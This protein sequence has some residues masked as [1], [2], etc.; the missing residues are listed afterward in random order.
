MLLSQIDADYYLVINDDLIFI[1]GSVDKPLAYMERP[2]NSRVGM[3]G[4][5]LLNADGSLQPSTYS[6]AGIFRAVLS[7]SN[8][9][10]AI[11]LTSKLF[12]LASFLRLD[13]GKSRYWPHTKTVEV[14]SFRGAYMLIRKAALQEVGLL[15]VKGGEE[16]EWH[17]RFHKHGW[18]VIFFHE[19]EIIHL[20][21]MTT[22]TDP[23]SELIFL[24]SFLNIYYK[25]MSRWRYG[26]LRFCFF[27]TYLAKYLVEKVR[28]TAQR[29]EFARKGLVMI[30]YW[31]QEVD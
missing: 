17:M 1:P 10:S 24:R 18:K 5:R 26:V 8:L 9:R 30:W 21:S 19:A 12:R 6:F 28:G 13:N 31:P 4:V 23:A 22:S 11:P 15:D 25:H 7:I 29:Q 3:L 20:G 2:E 14:E 16:T 27:L